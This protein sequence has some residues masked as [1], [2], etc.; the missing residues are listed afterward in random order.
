MTKTCLGR[1]GELSIITRPEG[2]VRYVFRDEIRVQDE[3][4][5]V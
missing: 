2:R 5:A 4:A 3:C 1:S